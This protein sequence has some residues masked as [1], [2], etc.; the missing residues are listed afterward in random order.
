M[1]WRRPYFLSAVAAVS[2]AA[3]L[4]LASA[5]NRWRWR[6]LLRS[7]SA[8]QLAAQQQHPHDGDAAV[9]T[10]AKLARQKSGQLVQEGKMLLYGA[11]CLA[12]RNSATQYAVNP[13]SVIHERVVIAMVGVPAR[14]KSYL[15]KSIVRVKHA[16]R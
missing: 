2:A 9:D 14:G 11:V 12:Q 3:A 1:A 6:L 10:L 7:A 16:L 15:S 4:V 8:D 13:T 5:W